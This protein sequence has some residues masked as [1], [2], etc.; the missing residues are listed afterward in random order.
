MFSKAAILGLAL[1][2]IVSAAPNPQYQLEST[3]STV[4]SW[5]TYEIETTV[6]YY[7]TETYWQTSSYTVEGV[8]SQTSWYPAT[9][10]IVTSTPSCIETSYPVTIWM[11]KEITT[12]VPVTNYE[13]YTEST[14]IEVP[15]CTTVWTS[16]QQLDVCTEY[17]STCITTSTAI[18]STTCVTCEE[19]LPTTTTYGWKA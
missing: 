1:V 12:Q 15:T 8:V 18:V 10:T 4:T 19:V 5:S 6:A 16:V 9:K 17:S 11:T 3:C 2:A 7:E 14:M 13:T